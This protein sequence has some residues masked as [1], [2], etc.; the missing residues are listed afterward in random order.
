M[1]SLPPPRAEE[2]TYTI[3]LSNPFQTRRH[4][5]SVITNPKPHTGSYDDSKVRRLSAF[6]MKLC[7]MPKGILVLPGLI[8]VWKSLTCDPILRGSDG[9]GIGVIMISC[10]C[11]SG[12]VQRFRRKLITMRGLPSKDFPSTILLLLLLDF[13]SLS[14]LWMSLLQFLLILRFWPMPKKSKKQKTSTSS[15]VAKR[16]RLATTYAAS[17][18]ARKNLCNKSSDDDDYDGVCKV[19]ARTKDIVDGRVDTPFKNAARPYSSAGTNPFVVGPSSAAPG[20]SS[21]DIERD[22]FPFVPGTLNERVET[23]K[24]TLVKATE[25]SKD[26]KKKSKSLS[27]AL[28]Q[29]TAKA[30]RVASDSNDARRVEAQ[31]RG[32]L[33]LVV[34]VGFE[35]GLRLN[36]NE[37]Q[38]DEAMKKISKFM[39]GAQDKLAKPTPLVATMKYLYMYK[40]VDHMD[41]PL[42]A[43][44]NLESDR[45]I[46]PVFAYIPRVVVVSPPSP[47]ELTITLASPPRELVSKDRP[48][49][50][51]ADESEQPPKERNEE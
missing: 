11:S 51:K 26:R 25:K 22:F 42:S 48:S 43:L 8:R 3:G 18:S 40:V 30:T 2:S 4:A 29:F 5:D 24:T 27:Q 49:L 14:L 41:R 20:T 33:S 28:D 19:G 16:T 32:L 13:P 46:R 21:N 15:Q 39:H 1:P 6:V 45:L 17:G 36:H 47:K 7:D 34:N 9:N 35:R 50:F 44:T 12:K 38:L 23:S 31:I 37:E 10:V